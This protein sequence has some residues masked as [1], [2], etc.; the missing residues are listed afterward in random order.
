MLPETKITIKKDGSLLIEG[1][2]K[3]DQCHKLEELAQMMG[4][5]DSCEDKEH[6]PVHQTVHQK[7]I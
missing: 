4:K 7:E 5:V 3:S 2:E 6:D 1:M